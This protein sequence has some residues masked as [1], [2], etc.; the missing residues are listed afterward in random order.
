MK[1]VKPRNELS[2]EP[3]CEDIP[4]RTITCVYT[5]PHTHTR[6]EGS[7]ERNH[8]SPFLCPLIGLVLI[9]AP[10]R[11]LLLAGAYTPLTV[12]LFLLPLVLVPSAIGLVH[13]GGYLRR[14][15]VSQ[16][17]CRGCGYDLRGGG[18]GCPECG[19]PL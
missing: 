13:G 7:G 4:K 5:H 16:G 9:L 10:P 15:R 17:T 18:A 19:K 6:D 1:V 14:A 2:I 11:E 8:V 12:T 3:W